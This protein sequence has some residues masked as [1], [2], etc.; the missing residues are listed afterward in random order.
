MARPFWLS[1]WAQSWSSPAAATHRIIPSLSS[2]APWSQNVSTLSMAQSDA[3]RPPVPQ[4]VCIYKPQIT[5]HDFGLFLY[6]SKM[7]KCMCIGIL[8]VSS[9]SGQ[10]TGQFALNLSSA[11]PAAGIW[12]GDIDSHSELSFACGGPN[13]LDNFKLSDLSFACGSQL[14]KITLLS[15]LNLIWAQGRHSVLKCWNSYA[16][17]NLLQGELMTRCK[18]WL[19]KQQFHYA[20]IKWWWVLWIYY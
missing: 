10:R 5:I 20:N 17:C 15:A 13:S 9:F 19:W 16:L 11:S 18:F 1:I 14:S 8:Q 2:Q 3:T 6:W 7:S 4:N 12:P